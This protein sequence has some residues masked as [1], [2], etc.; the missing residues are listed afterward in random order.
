MSNKVSIS[1]YEEKQ[2]LML[3]A[4]NMVGIPIDYV[5]TD[6]VHTTLL[7]FAEKKGNMDMLDAATIKAEHVKKW[8]E[9]FEKNGTEKDI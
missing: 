9:Y 5:T 6:L 8:N 4:F 2:H 1:D 3:I 7:K